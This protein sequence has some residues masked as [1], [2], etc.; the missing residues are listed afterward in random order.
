[1][2]MDFKLKLSKGI[3]EKGKQSMPFFKFTFASL[4]RFCE[5]DWGDTEPEDMAINNTNPLHATAIYRSSA[6]A[7]KIQRDSTYATVTLLTE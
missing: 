5:H 1:M 2:A 4:S 3:I 6:G 7:L